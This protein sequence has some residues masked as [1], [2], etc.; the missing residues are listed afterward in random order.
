MGWW[1]RCWRPVRSGWPARP[2]GIQPLICWHPSV[3]VQDSNGEM[4]PRFW[5]DFG[6]IDASITLHTAITPWCPSLTLCERTKSRPG[7]MTGD[8]IAGRSHMTMTMTDDIIIII[9]MKESQNGAGKR[10]EEVTRADTREWRRAA[11]RWAFSNF[12]AMATTAQILI[13]M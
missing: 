9:D 1:R 7:A 13:K 2:Q 6:T 5:I 11:T 4:T 10:R 8:I 3:G 12:G